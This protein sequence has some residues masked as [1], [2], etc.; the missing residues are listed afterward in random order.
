[1]KYARSKLSKFAQ[2]TPTKPQLLEGSSNLEQKDTYTVENDPLKFDTLSILSSESASSIIPEPFPLKPTINSK[3][4]DKRCPKNNPIVSHESIKLGDVD[5][6]LAFINNK[7]NPES[8][9][10]LASPKWP[11]HKLIRTQS[12]T[13][14]APK[15][16]K[17][18]VSQAISSSIP[19]RRK[20]TSSLSYSPN[21]K[22]YDL[23]NN[24]QINITETQNV[25]PLGYSK[26]VNK[27]VS[28]KWLK[29]LSDKPDINEYCCSTVD[30]PQTN[31]KPLLVRITTATQLRKLATTP[32]VNNPVLRGWS[33]HNRLGD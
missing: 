30:L 11:T 26:K 3:R 1:M 28:D 22:I 25:D 24:L 8:D 31:S 9:H 27:Q 12:M 5:R 33:S 29:E 17:Q 15:H 10:Q 20:L 32:K 13:C 7:D 4:E 2:P 23:D 6:M 14:P 18:T 19:L 16:D 21:S